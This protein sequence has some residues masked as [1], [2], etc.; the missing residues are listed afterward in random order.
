MCFLLLTTDRHPVRRPDHPVLNLSRFLMGSEP[1][2]VLATGSCQ[3]DKEIMS[4]EG[5]EA[6]DTASIVVRFENGEDAAPRTHCT[7]EPG[8]ALLAPHSPL[9]D[10]CST[11]HVLPALH[12]LHRQG[13]NH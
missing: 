4:L 11:L 9:T 7:A 12:L 5:P 10:P 1:V 3:I 13:R 2:K 8:S 6:F